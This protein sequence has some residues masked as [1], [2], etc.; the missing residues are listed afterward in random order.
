MQV[1][2]IE[3]IE[4]DGIVDESEWANV[5]LLP[6]RQQNPIFDTNPTELSE[7]FFAYDDEYIY[8]AGR[9]YYEDP[10]TMQSTTKLRDANE[11]STEY[12]GFILDTFNDN[13]NA[14][15]FFTTPAGLRWDGTVSNDAEGRM[16]I[17]TSWNTFWDVK[18]ELTDYG[19][20]TEIRVP[21]TSLRFQNI[22][23]VTTMGMTMW[24]YLPQKNEMI[25]FPLVSNDLGPM[26]FWK[27]SRMQKVQ[28]E[29]IT[30]KKPVYVAPYLLAGRFE[31]NNLNADETAYVNEVTND[32]EAG[33]D[34][35]Y[36]L[37]S[38]LTMDL[39][40]NPDFAQ[41]EVD[42][43]QVNLT[44][45]SLFFPEKRLFF[46]ERASVF[47]FNTGGPNT[48]FYS[49]RIGLEASGPVRIYGGARLVGRVGKW[50]IGF[51]DMQTQRVDSIRSTNYGVLRFRRQVINDFT[52]V[53]GML[54]N[55]IDDQGRYNTS[56]GV[57]LIAR[58]STNDYM[59]IGYAQTFYNDAN[60]HLFDPS[61]TNARIAFTSRKNIGFGY[62]TEVGRNGDRYNPEMGFENRPNDIKSVNRFWYTWFPSDS[63]P[64]LNHGPFVRAVGF[65]KTDTRIAESTFVGPG[66]QFQSRQGHWGDIGVF[67]AH[68]RVFDEFELSNDVTVPV[69]GYD[70]WY[71]EANLASPENRRLSV[72]TTYSLGQLY[73][74]NQLVLG[75]LPSWKVSPSLILNTEYYY[76]QVEFSERGESFQA[77]LGR[78]RALV[79]LNTSLSASIYV[80]HNSASNLSSGNFRFRF[81]PREGNDLFIVYNIGRYSN[82]NSLSP[83]LPEL[84]GQSIIL[85]YTYTFVLSKN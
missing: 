60:S 24:R 80:Q 11:G 64:I 48:L 51:L 17:N 30:P 63:S 22:D 46:Q 41:V 77:H 12:F 16:P 72:T 45:F 18:V 56:V 79:M 66:W 7:V 58:L 78:L 2:R 13:E 53:G 19:W 55:K 76:N 44:R 38:N 43:Q 20:Q 6:L 4:F 28:F 82:R 50:D 5:P 74:G 52:Y 32:F 3:N 37:T 61:T 35:K 27:P 65:W 31:Q 33:L 57:D 84:A 85:K 73:D 36:S 69:N 1:R 40:V 42:D 83:M 75:I 34:L 29:S 23:G 54:A 26:S 21:L 39:T 25:M 68:E 67:K 70:F 47:S 59:E 71:M 8:L 10:S 49:R 81:N 62:F 15:G 14:L 9:L